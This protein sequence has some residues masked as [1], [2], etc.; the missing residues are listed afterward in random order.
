MAGTNLW[1]DDIKSGKDFV[2]FELR[3]YQAPR[4]PAL[5]CHALM[6]NPNLEPC[7]IC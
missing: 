5:A 6:G 1:D 4:V 3:P 2:G 7:A